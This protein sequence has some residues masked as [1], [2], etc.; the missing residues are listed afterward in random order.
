MQTVTH[1]EANQV[2]ATLRGNYSGKRFRAIIA[3]RVTIPASAG[4]WDGGSRQTF[5]L[6]DMTTGESVPASDNVSAPW[7][8]RQDRVIE[9]RPGYCVREHSI[10]CGK[11]MGLR[12][13]VHPDNAAKLLPAPAAPLTAH[14]RMV[15]DATCTL[16]ASYG[17]RDRYQMV[18]DD[19][20]FARKEYPT[21]AQW[22]EAKAALIAKGLLNKAGAVTVAGRNA[23]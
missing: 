9:L 3:E 2:P 13:Y 21:R 12:F 23:R 22:D 7:D 4:N 5:A 19:L 1:L 17:G 15:L 8:P 14:E 11:D 16:K 10:F 6:L 18:T 20:R